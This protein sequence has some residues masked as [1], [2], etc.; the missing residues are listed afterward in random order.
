MD[1]DKL[2][3][4][5]TLLSS[6]NHGQAAID[7]LIILLRLGFILDERTT[8][9]W[10]EQYSMIMM[11]PA[12]YLDNKLLICVFRA[13]LLFFFSLIQIDLYILWNS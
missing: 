12:E 6:A 13:L 8:T 9:H 10:T 3:P 11:Q 7:G 2:T 5:W 1:Y 4:G